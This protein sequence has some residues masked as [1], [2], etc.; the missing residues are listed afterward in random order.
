[1]IDAV[2]STL[3]LDDYFPIRNS[4]EHEEFGKPHPGVY[5]ATMQKLGVD[6]DA[7]LAL[8]DSLNGVKSAK[9]AGMKCIAVPEDISDT[10]FAIADVVL[11]S[12]KNIDE[13]VWRKLQ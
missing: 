11:P 9:A 2:L 12:L 10:R 7:C 13:S 4:A 8:E 5:L 6:P 1:M 3:G